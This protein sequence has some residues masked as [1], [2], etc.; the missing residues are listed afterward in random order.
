MT[1]LDKQILRHMIGRR[2][3]MADDLLDLAPRAVVA[4]ALARLA[5]AGRLRRVGPA[6]YDR[7]CWDRELGMVVAP[8]LQGILDALTRRTGEILGPVPMAAADALGLD[9]GQQWRPVYSTSGRSRRV[10]ASGWIIELERPRP[11]ARPWMGRPGFEVLQALIYIRREAMDPMV[12]EILA[13]TLTKA[14]RW[15]LLRGWVQL[16]G[17]VREALGR[18]LQLPAGE[19][20]RDMTAA[21]VR[22]RKGLS[23]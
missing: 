16:P 7:P 23:G 3:V 13:C 10:R 1:D 2:V 11:W 6:M 15:D 14:Q 9:R 5:R 4:R 22:K 12:A 8:C 20:R 19:Y 17:W 18:A 21:W